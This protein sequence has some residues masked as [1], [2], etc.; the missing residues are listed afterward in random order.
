[1]ANYKDNKLIG[2][3][4]FG[5][6]RI[7]V[8]LAEKVL[9]PTESFK[10]TVNSGEDSSFMLPLSGIDTNNGQFLP[11]DLLV[12]WGDEKGE[13]EIV[14]GTSTMEQM[15]Y[16]HTYSQPNQNYQITIQPNGDTD[17]WGLAFGYTGTMM[18]GGSPMKD[19]EKII[20]LD[21][22]LT[23]SM[24]MKSGNLDGLCFGMFMMCTNLTMGDEFNLPQDM[25]EIGM[26]FCNQMFYGCT[27]LNMGAKFNLPQKLTSV[28]NEFCHMMFDGCLK[29]TMNDTF[30]LPQNITSIGTGFCQMMFNGCSNLTMN[31]TF[32]LPQNISGSVDERFCSSMFNDCSKLTMNSIF[33]LPQGITS[34]GSAFCGTYNAREVDGMFG[35]CTSLEIN[36]V[37]QLPQ[38]MTKDSGTGLVCSA[39]FSGC[40]SIKNNVQH[41]FGNLVLPKESLGD[42][43]FSRCFENMFKN[44]VNITEEISA[45]TIPQLAVIPTKNNDCFTGASEIARQYCPVNW[46]GKGEEKP[47]EPTESFKFTVNSGED[48]SFI[49]PL[50]GNEVRTYA[51]DY[52]LLVDWGDESEPE[53]V[54]GT[55]SANHGVSHTYANANQN[56][57]I[58][59]QPN[60]D[61]DGWGVAFGFGFGSE[62][63]NVQTNKDKIISLDSP[64]TKSMVSKNGELDGICYHMFEGCT[65]LTMGASFN[66]PQNITSVGSNFARYMFEGCTNLTMGAS[67]NLPQGITSVGIMFCQNM[68]NGCTNLTMNEVFQLPQG[69]ISA[70]NYFCQGMFNGCSKLTMN[71]VFNLPQGITSVRNYVCQNM[72][73]GC[74]NLTMNEVFQLP[75]GITYAGNSFCNAMFNGCTNLVSGIQHF[76][77]NLVLSQGELNKSGVFNST[78]ATCTG[79]NEEISADTIPQLAISPTATN[80]CFK[81]ANSTAIANCPTNWK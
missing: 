80:E 6:E 73:N 35:N 32:Q 15:G 64:L 20:S 56:Y 21:S 38:N 65:N 10:F 37:F 16:T 67:F 54:Q 14:Q 24:I 30:Q 13:Q 74:S 72:F 59:I 45:D 1:M 9:T 79:I 5:S 39:M 23:K 3:V 11:Y 28:G 47:Q 2:A 71:S 18:S 46:G 58:T 19:A 42:A 8:L 50:A 27:N 69:I 17:G 40:S 26:S 68:F 31:D 57:Q 61:T 43:S 77:G 76:F 44:C 70:V 51:S 29:L 12:D 53:V 41:V 52:D 25:T 81:S 49:L 34:V 66:L 22:P 78:F 55:S 62:G 75:Q 36:D 7:K 48:S 60:G 63:C 4:Y 33:Q